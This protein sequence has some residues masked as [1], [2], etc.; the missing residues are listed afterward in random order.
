MLASIYIVWV[1]WAWR[2][3]DGTGGMEN[4][5][6]CAL[7]SIGPH[8]EVIKHAHTDAYTLTQAHTD[9]YTLTQAHLQKHTP[10]VLLGCIHIVMSQRNTSFCS[11][12]KWFQLNWH[13]RSLAVS[14]MT[15]SYCLPSL[16]CQFYLWKGYSSWTHFEMIAQ[17]FRF[18]QTWGSV[19]WVWKYFYSTWPTY[20][21]VHLLGTCSEI[22][23]KSELVGSTYCVLQS[24]NNWS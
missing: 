12:G 15:S 7:V 18:G 4:L 2:E 10:W 22:M 23:S 11:T 1:G 8:G 5:H 9:A 24:K 16:Q 19:C 14:S 21:V 20:V 3:H 17:S 13:R 6:L